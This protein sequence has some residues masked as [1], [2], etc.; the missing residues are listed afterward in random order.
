MNEDEL[1]KWLHS[2]DDDDDSETPAKYQLLTVRLFKEAIREAEGNQGEILLASFA[3]NV[4]PNLMQ[5]LV[6]ATAK[7]GQFTEDRRAEGKNV[8]RSKHDQSF[9]SHLLNGLFPTYRILKKLKTDTPETNPVKRNC[10]ETEIALF[11]RS[12]E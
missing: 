6:G 9:T 7:G 1:Y 4:L 12:E 3:E 10:G 8:D 2:P 5:Q 11:I